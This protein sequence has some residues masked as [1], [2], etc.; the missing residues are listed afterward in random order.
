MTFKSYHKVVYLFA[1]GLLLAMLVL[2]AAGGMA[3]DSMAA[4]N[5]GPHLTLFQTTGADDAPAPTFIACTA[6]ESGCGGG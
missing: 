4:T 5:S 1:I 6:S 2:S 3:I